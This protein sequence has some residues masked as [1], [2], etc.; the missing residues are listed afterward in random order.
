M[1]ITETMVLFWGIQDVYSNW[2][3]AVF[4]LGGRENVNNGILLPQQLPKQAL[5]GQAFS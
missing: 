4:T 5:V 2:H 3:P 1:K